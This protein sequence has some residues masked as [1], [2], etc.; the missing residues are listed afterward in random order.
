MLLWTYFDHESAIKIGYRLGI[1][2]GCREIVLENEADARIGTVLDTSIR[3]TRYAISYTR[4][5][6]RRTRYN[7]RYF[8]VFMPHSVFKHT[9]YVGTSSTKRTA[10]N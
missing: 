10:T 2:L 6:V 7:V 9:Y 8:V 4:Y 1:S 5:S 3:D